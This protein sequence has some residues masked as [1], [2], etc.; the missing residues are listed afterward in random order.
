MQFA[1]CKTLLGAV[2]NKG[3][4]KAGGVTGQP[5]RRLLQPGQAIMLTGSSVEVRRWGKHGE[6][7]RMLL[8]LYNW[9]LGKKA[10]PSMGI[11][12]PC[13]RLPR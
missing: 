1:L 12:N 11:S 4:G 7:E 8:G 6:E 5:M 13:P 10:Q 9:V 2:T 3:W